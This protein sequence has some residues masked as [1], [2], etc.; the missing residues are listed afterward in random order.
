MILV[1]SCV[2]GNKYVLTLHQETPIRL[3]GC[4]RDTELCR[5][6]IIEQVYKESLENCDFDMICGTKN[7]AEDKAY[8]L[9]P[10]SSNST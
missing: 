3:P 9:M 6:D 1:Y 7:V 8:H 10:S 4:P 5:L 2:D